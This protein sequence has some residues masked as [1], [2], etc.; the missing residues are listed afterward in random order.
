MTTTTPNTPLS[1]D[2]TLR[3]VVEQLKQYCTPQSLHAPVRRIAHPPLRAIGLALMDG[4]DTL[5][6]HALSGGYTNYSY[7]IHLKN[8]P[9][10]AVF[11]KVALDHALWASQ[12]LH[13]S[14]DRLSTEFE[15]QERFSRELPGTVAQPYL[16]ITENL[17]GNMSIMITEWSENT[18]TMLGRQ[19]L[20]DSILQNAS[21]LPKL[22]QTIAR[23]NLSSFESSLNQEWVQ[24]FQPLAQGFDGML[25]GLLEKENEDDAA[26]PRAYRQSP[27]RV[28]GR[29]APTRP[30]L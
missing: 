23:I 2:E 6:G 9:E 4:A 28:V 22:A 5:T 29:T 12:E 21:V 17:P 16:L 11:A 26:I 30:G 3:V 24:S 13:Y 20:D 14:L 19:F 10:V 15:L 25:L 7:K 27:G 8:S 18:N 1:R